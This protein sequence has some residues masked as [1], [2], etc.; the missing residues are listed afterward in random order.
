MLTAEQQK[1]GLTDREVATQNGWLQQTFSRWKMGSLPRPHMY[2]SIA[3]FLGVPIE[4][5]KEAVEEATQTTRA[6]TVSVFGAA[7]VHGTISDR[8]EGKFKFP[9]PTYAAKNV[10]NGRYAI[11]IDTKVMEPALLVGTKAWLDPAVWPL[12]GHEVLV[13]TKSGA[14]WI[15]RLVEMGNGTARLE[16][17]NAAPLT[18]HDVRSVHVIVLSERVAAGG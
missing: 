14:A 1:L 17:Y 6:R 16:R 13:H 15:G 7:A 3:D 12:V 8:K 5:V 9:P 2:A 11:L 18:I 10:P 4:T